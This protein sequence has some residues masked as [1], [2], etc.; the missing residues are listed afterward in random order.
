MN[1]VFKRPPVPL[2]RT[3]VIQQGVSLY[4]NIFQM[5]FVLCSTMDIW[6]LNTVHEIRYLQFSLALKATRLF[7]L[8]L[9]VRSGGSTESLVK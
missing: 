5:A 2:A 4:H 9:W 8:L 3:H 1:L 7:V 6:P